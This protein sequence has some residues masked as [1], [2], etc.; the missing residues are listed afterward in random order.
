VW[1]VDECLMQAICITTDVKVK[2]IV[3]KY[4]LLYHKTIQDEEDWCR[5]AG[6]L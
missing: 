4:Y 1:E 3:M 2:N 6:V 5:H